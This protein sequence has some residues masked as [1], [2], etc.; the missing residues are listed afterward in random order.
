MRLIFKKAGL[1]PSII[2]SDRSNNAVDGIAKYS[3]TDTSGAKLLGLLPGK[4]VKAGSILLHTANVTHAYDIR[5]SKYLGKHKSISL[6][7]ESSVPALIALL[8]GK[9]DNVLCFAPSSG[10]PG[11]KINIAITVNVSDS[12][13]FNSVA[14]VYVYDPS[15]NKESI[16]VGIVILSMEPQILHL[17]QRLMIRKAGGK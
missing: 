12:M 17:I 1:A 8:P 3:F 16:T 4:N 5:N 15:G 2:L 13:H 9:I 10:K 7:V 14:S 11:E 6:E